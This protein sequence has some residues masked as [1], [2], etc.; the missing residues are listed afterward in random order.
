[1]HAAGCLGVR[2]AYVLRQ[3]EHTVLNRVVR[4][5]LETFLAEARLRGGGEGLARFVR[6][7]GE[8]ETGNRKRETGNRKRNRRADDEWWN[9]ES[10]V[11]AR[12]KGDE[13]LPEVDALG[14]IL[15]T[16]K[17]T[18]VSVRRRPA[19]HGLTQPADPFPVLRFCVSSFRFPVF[20]FRLP[21]SG[22]IT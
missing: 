6:R 18:P 22:S 1:V 17:R 20:R 9:G 16:S 15:G 5:H 11:P 14:R 12:M 21:V 3:P 4:E 13:V 2:R 10:E 7:D 8:Q 19:T